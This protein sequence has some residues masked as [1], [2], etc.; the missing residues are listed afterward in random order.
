MGGSIRCKRVYDPP[1]PGD[2]MRILV[3]R[4]WPRGI[5]KADAAIDL[6]MKEIA[7]SQGLRQWFGHDAARW[8]EFQRRYRN[9]LDANEESVA[10]LLRLAGEQGLTLVYAARDEP[11]NSAQVLRDYLRQRLR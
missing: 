11:G 5:R 6:W 2:G 8:E 10:E 7:P 9:E 4:L 1:A 3:E